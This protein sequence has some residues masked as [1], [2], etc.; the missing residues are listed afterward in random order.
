MNIGIPRET[1]SGEFRVALIPDHIRLLT[2]AGHTVFVQKD[3]GKKCKFTN[4]DYEKAEA[5]ESP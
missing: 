3:A 5:Y 1:K 4:R 2:L